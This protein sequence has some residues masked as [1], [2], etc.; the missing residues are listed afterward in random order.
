MQETLN[1]GIK[2][3]YEKFILGFILFIPGSYHT[4]IAFGA[5]TGMHGY[6]Y[7]NLTTFESESFFE[8]DDWL[9]QLN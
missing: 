1:L 6:N 2:E 3:S 8:N 7:D 5:L 4:F 9:M